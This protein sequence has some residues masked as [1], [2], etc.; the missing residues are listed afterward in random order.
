MTSR[1]SASATNRSTAGSLTGDLFREDTRNRPRGDQPGR[2]PRGRHGAEPGLDK[3]RRG[4]AGGHRLARVDGRVRLDIVAG[5][6]R[7]Q[8]QFG[9]PSLDPALG[10]EAFAELPIADEVV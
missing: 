7:E 3:L 6:D 5:A 1:I 4:R 10:V 2:H 8:R 9:E